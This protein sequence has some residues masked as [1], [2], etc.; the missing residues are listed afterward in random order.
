MDTNASYRNGDSPL[1]WGMY[2]SK[3]VSGDYAAYQEAYIDKVE[4]GDILKTMSAQIDRAVG[5]LERFSDEGDLAYDEGKWTVKQVIQHIIDAERVF[6]YRILCLSRGD[7]TPLPGFDENAYAETGDVDHRTVQD[8]I[9]E[10]VA[11]RSGTF[12]LVKSLHGEMLSQSGI[13]SDYRITVPALL[14]VTIGH[15]EHHL[16]ILEER[17]APILGE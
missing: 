3:P 2:I 13:T 1:F 4:E 11:V 10:L 9:A 6:A 17:Y 12:A 14:Y 5:L 15:V 7:A 8:L 16:D